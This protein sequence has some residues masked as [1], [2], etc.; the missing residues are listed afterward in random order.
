M[1]TAIPFLVL[2]GLHALGCVSAPDVRPSSSR[3]LLKKS[4]WK[5][6]PQNLARGDEQREP[7]S[8]QLAS[9]KKQLADRS[10]AD[11]PPPAPDVEKRPGDSRPADLDSEEEKKDDERSWGIF[12]HLGYSIYTGGIGGSLEY[13]YNWISLSGGVGAWDPWE[14]ADVIGWAVGV[15]VFPLGFSWGPYAGVTYGLVAREEYYRDDELES[16]KN[17]LGPSFVGG[18][19]FV[20]DQENSYITFDVGAGAAY[21]PDIPDWAKGAVGEWTLVLDLSV[22]W[23]AAL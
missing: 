5:P 15:K 3:I 6:D 1:K 2:I 10:G 11:A 22:G 16:Q 13:W 12:A 21:L 20:I 9:E 19:R 23:G 4:P 17:F 18:F 8:T 7:G 14:E